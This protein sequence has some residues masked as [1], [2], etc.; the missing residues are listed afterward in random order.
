MPFLTAVSTDSFPLVSVHQLPATDFTQ[1][2]AIGWQRKI[3]QVFG[4]NIEQLVRPTKDGIKVSAQAVQHDREEVLSVVSALL[5][6]K[7]AGFKA[8]K[9]QADVAKWGIQKAGEEQV[10]AAIQVGLYL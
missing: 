6:R 4:G 3:D 9:V 8:D 5:E 7:K 2:I 1:E 10:A